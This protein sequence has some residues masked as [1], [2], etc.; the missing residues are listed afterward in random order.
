MVQSAPIPDNN[1][2]KDE[3]QALK[4]LK[5]DNNIVILPADKGR[6]TVV[7]DKT[8]YFDGDIGGFQTPQHRKK[9]NE[10][11]ITARKV[12]ETPSPQHVFLAP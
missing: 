3:Q 7:I 6:V 10:H 5:N 1:L 2:T 8:D 11:R 4:R 9:I 12:N